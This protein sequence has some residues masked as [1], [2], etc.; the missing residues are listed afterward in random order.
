MSNIVCRPYFE[1]KRRRWS[2]RVPVAEVYVWED[3]VDQGFVSMELIAGNIPAYIWD[4][5]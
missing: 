1:S 2:G 5:T 3:G 4:A